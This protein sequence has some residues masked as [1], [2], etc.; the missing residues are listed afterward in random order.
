[1]EC[2]LLEQV[3]GPN[4]VLTVLCSESN[5]HAV[6]C[7]FA[8]IDIT[9]QHCYKLLY[10]VIDHFQ[11]YSLFIFLLALHLERDRPRVFCK[12]REILEAFHLHLWRYAV[13]RWILAIRSK[14]TADEYFP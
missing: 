1:M 6:V 8:S 11:I 10:Y 4:P 5:F 9:I 2:Y 7:V 3:E 13:S 12:L 14:I